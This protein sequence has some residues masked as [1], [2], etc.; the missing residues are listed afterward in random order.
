MR[1]EAF[2]G[3]GQSRSTGQGPGSPALAG[4]PPRQYGPRRGGFQ[5]RPV[6]RTIPPERWFCPA[7]GL[8]PHL[9]VLSFRGGRRLPWESVPLFCVPERPQRGCGLPRHFAPR[10]DRNEQFHRAGAGFPG[11]CRTPPHQY[12]PRRGGFQTR[13][14]HRTIPPERWFCPA[15][16]LSPHLP[17]LSFRGGRRL[18][19]ESVPL[20]CVP[21]RPQR[22][23]GLP[24]RF[25]PRNDRNERFHRAGA[26]FPGPCRTTATPIRT[27]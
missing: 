22:G 20:F 1:N 9:P 13:P 18:P 17:V 11:P 16:G 5:T 3:D 21:E 6:H 25:A 26:G 7:G 19:W 10:N 15:G 12:G 4:R 27:S 2:S 8:S 24:R 23:C 14:V